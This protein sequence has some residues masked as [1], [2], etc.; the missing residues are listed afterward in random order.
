MRIAWFLAAALAALSTAVAA[1]PLKVVGPWEIAGVD[2]AQSGYVFSR[3]QVAETLVTADTSGRLVPALAA[4]WS[5]SDDGLVWRFTLRPDAVFHDGTPVTAE[6]ATA[7]LERARA[8][9]GV[10]TQVPIAGIAGDGRDVVIRLDKP[11]AA[12]PA[13]LVNFSAI[14]LAPS[15]YDDA[16]KVSRIVGSGPYKVKSLTPPLKLELEA[17]R[18]WWGG[19][20]GIAEV[21]YLAVGQGETRALMAESGEADLVFS[22]LPVSVER[23]RRNGKLDVQIATIPRTRILKVNAGSPFFDDVKVRQAV[24]QAIDRAGIAKVILRNPDL[25][26]TQLF[27]PALAG[28][29]VPDL[30]PLGRDVEAAKRLLAEAGWKPGSDGILER[31]GRRFSVTLLTYANWPELPPIATAL[32]A[33]LR[34]V[35]IEVKV[36]VGNSSEIPS[37]HR[38]GTLEMGLVSRLYSIVPDPIGTLLQDYGPGGSDWGAMGWSNEELPAL[39]GRLV[40]MSDP[41]A[42]APLQRRAVE[43]LQE[44][45]PS[46]PV[47]W[48]E[49][50]IV[51]S[52]RITG[53]KVDPLEVNY[54]LAAVRWAE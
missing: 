47:T 25:A 52:K 18:G 33:Q 38:D 22:M 20:P 8:G 10:L 41:G 2:P 12:L 3:L 4:A 51:A 49:L 37:R 28:W 46:I 7:S 9:V 40:G 53:V 13:Y 17:S 35:G 34:E 14:I 16:G 45:L 29:H 24:S 48:S 15:S 11:F 27:P 31:D 5:V 42:R 50:A 1:K 39:V 36:S 54:G 44:E 32:Q 43:I 19:E 30:A 26:A 21:S 6:A 23:L